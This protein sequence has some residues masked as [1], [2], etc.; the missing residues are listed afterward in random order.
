MWTTF[1]V[2]GTSHAKQIQYV[3]VGT[4]SEVWGLERGYCADDLADQTRRSDD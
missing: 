1:A 3:D 2:P 4:S